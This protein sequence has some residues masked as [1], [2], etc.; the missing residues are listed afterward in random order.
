MAVSVVI[1]TV[2]WRDEWKS[3]PSEQKARWRLPLPLGPQT[4]P[5]DRLLL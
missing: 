2:T 3:T 1:V 5:W 4:P